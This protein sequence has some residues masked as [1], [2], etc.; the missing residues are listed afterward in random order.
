MYKGEISV[1]Q[2]QLSSL[3]KAAESLQVTYIY[4]LTVQSNASSC[5]EQLHMDG[6]VEEK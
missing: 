4:I 3:I 5:V 2:E 6:K 1:V